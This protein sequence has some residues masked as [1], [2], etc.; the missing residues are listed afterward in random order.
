MKRIVLYTMLLL[1]L[2]FL[3]SCKSAKTL[4]NFTDE[5]LR[6]SLSKG[7]CFGSCPVYELK[8]YHGGYATFLGIQNTDRIGLYEK[9][10]S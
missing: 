3:F 8:V 10:I 7:V 1:T 5:D 4:E 9:T 6:F 2:N